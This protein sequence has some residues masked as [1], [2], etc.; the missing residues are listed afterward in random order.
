MTSSTSSRWAEPAQLSG[1]HLQTSNFQLLPH[2]PHLRNLILSLIEEITGSE[3]FGC[4]DKNDMKN[5]KFAAKFHSGDHELRP[6]SHIYEHRPACHQCTCSRTKNREDQH[7]WDVSAGCSA[8]KLSKTRC[9]RI[10]SSRPR[11][12]EQAAVFSAF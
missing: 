3:N 1:A 9:A 11:G 12:L 6:Q 2:L 8:L 4:F 10:T 5:F 7:P